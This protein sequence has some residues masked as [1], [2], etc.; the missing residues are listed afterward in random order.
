MAICDSDEN[1]KKIFDQVEFVFDYEIKNKK[2]FLKEMKEY[3]S[4]LFSLDEI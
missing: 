1:V 3:L 2:N 4:Q